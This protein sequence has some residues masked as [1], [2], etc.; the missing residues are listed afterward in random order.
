MSNTNS[1]CLVFRPKNETEDHKYL[2]LME[3]LIREMLKDIRFAEIVFQF[4]THFKSPYNNFLWDNSNEIFESF[5]EASDLTDKDIEVYSKMAEGKFSTLLELTTSEFTDFRGAFLEEYWHASID[6]KYDEED[7]TVIREVVVCTET[8]EKSIV[9]EV[10]SDLD[11]L[12]FLDEISGK[13]TF[14]EC[15]ANVINFFKRVARNIEHS[16][17]DL[18]KIF[19]INSLL[20][21]ISDR[22]EITEVSVILASYNSLDQTDYDYISRKLKQAIKRDD[23]LF[24]NTSIGGFHQKW[25]DG[26]VL[27]FGK[28]KSTAFSV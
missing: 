10:D 23:N 8:S 3:P 7:L 24:Y 14:V 4:F 16:E 21:K 20:E 19:L 18:K 2:S 9:T 26:F 12:F 25:N 5:I 28:E 17:N 1:G 6:K 11:F 22:E 13:L 15:K 27:L